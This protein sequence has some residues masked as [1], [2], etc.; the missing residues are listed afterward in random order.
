MRA[1]AALPA[2][3]HDLLGVEP[4]LASHRQG[5]NPDSLLTLAATT[6]LNTTRPD[7]MLILATI[8]ILHRTN[9]DCCK[10]RKG[11]RAEMP[12]THVLHPIKYG[13]LPGYDPLA[14]RLKCIGERFSG[15]RNGLWLISHPATETFLECRTDQ[16][17]KK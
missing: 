16:L 17:E 15:R 10:S 12:P 8:T 9:P 1:L 2:A 7:S 3:P 11:F 4:I 6:L 5:C 13:V 14:F